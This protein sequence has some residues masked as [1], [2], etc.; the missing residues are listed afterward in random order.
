MKGDKQNFRKGRLKIPQCL[1]LPKETSPS[2]PTPAF[3]GQYWLERGEIKERGE[4]D[5]EISKKTSK[6]G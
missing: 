4:Y 5:E 2:I 1:S 3:S 6:E